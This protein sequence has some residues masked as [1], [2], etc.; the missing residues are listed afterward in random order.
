V[1]NIY[2]LNVMT[3]AIDR[4]TASRFGAFQPAASADGSTLFYS[5][6][7]KDGYRIASLPMDSV[8]QPATDFNRSTNGN[9]L[10][11][12]LSNQEAAIETAS[13]DTPIEFNPKPYRKLSHLFNFHSWAPLYYDVADIVSGGA[14]DFTTA[15]K[16]GMTIMSQNA[17]NTAFT[18][19]GWY[20]SGGRHHGVVNFTYKGLFPVILMQADYGGNAF[21]FRWHT[22]SLGADSASFNYNGRGLLTAKAQVYVPLNFS[23]GAWVR[24]LQTG[25]SYNFTNDRYEQ[26]DSHRMPFFQYVLGDV[27]AYAYRRQ[28][29]QEILPRWGAQLRLQY[30][31]PLFQPENMS[32]LYAARLTAYMPGAVRTHSL[33]M[34]L[35]YQYQPFGKAYLFTPKQ[36]TDFVRGYSYSFRTNQLFTLKADYAFPILMPDWSLPPVAYIRRL[37]G[38]VFYDAAWNKAAEDPYTMLASAGADIIMDWNALRLPYPLVTGIRFTQPLNYGR[39]QISLI[40]SMQF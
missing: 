30:L 39:P 31:M 8:S 13:T 36:L 22:S 9:T 18:Q 12:T 10:A 6:Y 33:M 7:G 3:G 2:S 37:R 1:N 16:P 29:V 20:Y 24:G 25:L 11:T 23:S 27:V 26:H 28:A 32:S 35:G 5:E 14:S 21:D 40:F 15:V 17:L 34:R 4:I 19:L 38:N